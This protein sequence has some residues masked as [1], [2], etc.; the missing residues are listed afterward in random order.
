M[1]AIGNEQLS[2]E[3]LAAEIRPDRGSIEVERLPIH[4]E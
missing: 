1:A 4:A 3:E 2:N